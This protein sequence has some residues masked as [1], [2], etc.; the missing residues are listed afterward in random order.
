M[1]GEWSLQN[2]DDYNSAGST[3]AG[4]KNVVVLFI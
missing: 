1:D 4:I 3:D 2:V